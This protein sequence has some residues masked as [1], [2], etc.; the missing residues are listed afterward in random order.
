MNDI[1]IKN[2]ESIPT[3]FLIKKFEE[4]YK[5]LGYEFFFI[6][7][8][9]LLEYLHLWDEAEK[10]KE[11]MS[12]LIYR[13]TNSIIKPEWLPKNYIIINTTF[14]ASSSTEVRKRIREN[15]KLHKNAYDDEEYDEEKYTSFETKNE[16]P[17]NIKLAGGKLKLIRKKSLH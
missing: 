16:M 11:E 9:D 2:K 4:E 12:F 14:V 17:Q 15:Y 10:M 1:E 5:E 7:G 3:Y 13:R 6:M 8:S